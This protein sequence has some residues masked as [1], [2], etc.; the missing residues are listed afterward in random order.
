MKYAVTLHLITGR[1]GIARVQD[2]RIIADFLEV[3]ARKACELLNADAERREK[4]GKADTLPVNVDESW[5]PEVK[6]RVRIKSGRGPF[7]GGTGLVTKTL[8]TQTE[9]IMGGYRHWFANEN[10]EPAEESA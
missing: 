8:R 10:L 5:K 7:V 9:V 3:D 1:Y 6:K 2:G 4:I